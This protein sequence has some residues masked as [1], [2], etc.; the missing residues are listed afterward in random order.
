MCRLRTQV[1]F[2]VDRAERLAPAP[3]DF[4]RRL[5]GGPIRGAATAAAKGP[6]SRARRR[7]GLGGRGD[8]CC[9]RATICAARRQG[10]MDERNGGG[11]VKAYGRRHPGG[12]GRAAA[13]GRQRSCTLIA[14]VQVVSLVQGVRAGC[15]AARACIVFALVRPAR[16]RAVGCRHGSANAYGKRAEWRGLPADPVFS[17]IWRSSRSKGRRQRCAGHGLTAEDGG[18]VGS[19]SN[20]R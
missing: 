8:S 17:W 7:S 20:G 11:A 14:D 15:G 9:G 12:R 5:R 1:A 13:P 19:G 6:A 16:S 3:R 4:L 10:G 2:H 18:R